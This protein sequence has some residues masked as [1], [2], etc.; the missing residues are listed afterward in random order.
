MKK[1]QFILPLSFILLLNNSPVFAAGA[2]AFIF[3]GFLSNPYIASLFV[4]LGIVSLILEIMTP[5]FGL[6]ALMSAVFF[7]LFFIGSVATG[8]ASIFTV[9]IFIIGIIL[10]IIELLIPG[11]GLPGIGGIIAMV[12]SISFAMSSLEHA[13]ITLLLATLISFGVSYYLIQKGYNSNWIK[14]VIHKSKILPGMTDDESFHVKIGD[15]GISKTNLRPSG[16]CEID[17]LEYSVM[18]ENGNYISKESVVEVTA[19]SGRTI[20]VKEKENE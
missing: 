3:I 5:G 1:N 17:G 7:A 10:L 2:E 19:I 11:F 15:I 16:N 4:I 9:F 8:L 12:T 14:K 18:A 6:G 20:Y 13:A